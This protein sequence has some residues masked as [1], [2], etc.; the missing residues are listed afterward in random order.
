MPPHKPWEAHPSFEY[1]HKLPAVEVTLLAPYLCDRCM[2]FKFDAFGKH[3]PGEHVKYPCPECDNE[4]NIPPGGLMYVDAYAHWYWRHKDPN[5][6][7][8]DAAIFCRLRYPWKGKESFYD[9]RRSVDL[10]QVWGPKSLEQRL[11]QTTARVLR[12]DEHHAGAAYRSLCTVSPVVWP[13]SWPKPSARVMGGSNRAYEE[14]M[15]GLDLPA[16][17][18][19]VW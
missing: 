3:E 15:A 13:E 9:M 14:I 4:G 2:N 11:L 18:I 6:G 5:L 17:R 19:L 16:E 1:T 10:L 8:F 12:G 7:I